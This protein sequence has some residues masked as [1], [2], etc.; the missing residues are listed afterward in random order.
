M[1]SFFVKGKLMTGDRALSNIPHELTMMNASKPMVISEKM[2]GYTSFYR[3]IKMAFDNDKLKIVSIVE[4]EEDIARMERISS[5]VEEYKK[6]GADSIIAVGREAT[7]SVAKLVCLALKQGVSDIKSI[8]SIKPSDVEIPLIVVPIF[9]GSGQEFSGFARCYDDNTAYDFLSDELMPD[10]VVV[11]SEMIFMPS[12]EVGASTIM[13]ALSTAIMAYTSK[14]NNILTKST[15]MSSIELLCKCIND[16]L[17]MK[18]PRAFGTEL[19]TSV[20]L[21]GIAHLD[22]DND[23]DLAKMSKI[24]A[25]IM[26]LPYSKVYSMLFPHYYEKIINDTDLAYMEVLLPIIGEERYSLTPISK[27]ASEVVHNVRI[28]INYL[29]AKTGFNYNLSDFNVR[30]ED[31]KQIADAVEAASLPHDIVWYTLEKTF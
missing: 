4:Y 18:K 21:S 28:L 13:Y 7:I 5:F 17:F 22:I 25:K 29:S 24:V 8:E 16:P 19:A 26:R 1:N 2:E 11:D 15:A 31:L 9:Y 20:V 6:S 14:N 12:R 27:R 10:A 23:D 3:P 30:R